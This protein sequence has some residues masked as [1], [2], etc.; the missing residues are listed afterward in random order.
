MKQFKFDIVVYDEKETFPKDVRNSKFYYPFIDQ[1]SVIG[2]Y[3][4]DHD[5]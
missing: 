1:K 3:E 4:I 2:K 5:G